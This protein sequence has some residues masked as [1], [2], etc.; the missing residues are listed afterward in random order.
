MEIQTEHLILRPWCQEDYEPFARLNAD[1]RVMEYFPHLLS[2]QESDLYAQA[3]QKEIDREGWGAWAVS[4]SGTAGFIGTIGL[5]KV[6][7]SV[8]FMPAVEIAWR[9]AYDFWGQGYATEG[10]HAV[11]KYGF[12]TLFLDEIVAYTAAQ[13]YRSRRVME[14]IGMTYNPKDDFDHPKI[15]REHKLSRCV[16][17]R[18][19]KVDWITDAQS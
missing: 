18:I 15:A 13:N 7:L 16:L 17:Y 2:R 6:D 11:L 14:K 5:K 4:I 10:A 8:H 1:S 19:K 9:L 12:D 3:R